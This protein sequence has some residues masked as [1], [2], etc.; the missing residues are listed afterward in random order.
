MGNKDSKVGAPGGR[1]DALSMSNCL[2]QMCKNMECSLK[3]ELNSCTGDL[4]IYQISRCRKILHGKTKFI[5]NIN[6]VL[7]NPAW[8]RFVKL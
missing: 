6:L 8:Q 5:V 7:R 2:S 3:K 4:A 1:D